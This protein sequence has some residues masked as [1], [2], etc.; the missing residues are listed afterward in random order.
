MNKDTSKPIPIPNQPRMYIIDGKKHYWSPRGDCFI[1]VPKQI[2]AKKT[3][4]QRI[5]EELDETPLD[6]N[7]M[8]ERIKEKWDEDKLFDEQYIFKSIIKGINQNLIV[9]KKVNSEKN[10]YKGHSYRLASTEDGIS[11]TK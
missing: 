3:Y 4:L 6:Y 10:K 5:I 8:L 11:N 9:Q 2:K 1:P 7:I